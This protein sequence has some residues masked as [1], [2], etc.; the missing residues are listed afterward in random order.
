MTMVRSRRKSKCFINYLIIDRI[1]MFKFNY[2]REILLKTDF[3][4]WIRFW[5]G[6]DLRWIR[7]KDHKYTHFG[8]QPTTNCFPLKIKTLNNSNVKTREFSLSTYNWTFE[9]PPS[10]NKYQYYLGLY[11]HV[12]MQQHRLRISFKS[13]IYMYKYRIYVYCI[14]KDF[15]FQ[16]DPVFGRPRLFFV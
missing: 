8:N 12:I 10:L 1:L 7:L 5:R 11:F 2:L 16:V 3:Q 14:V 13:V 6:C 15:V 9:K 4:R